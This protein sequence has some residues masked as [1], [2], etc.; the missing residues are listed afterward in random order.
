MEIKQFEKYSTEEWV[1]AGSIEDIKDNGESV[2]VSGSSVAAV[3]KDSN[4]VT[5]TVLDTGTL[6]ADGDYLKV[7]CR[8]GSEAASP[9]TITYTMKT[10]AGNT[11][12]VKG[13]MWVVDV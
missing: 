7:L 8:A 2:Q 10:D 11:Y 1:S 9:Y 4:D 12:V 6:A 3:D 5:S 13:E